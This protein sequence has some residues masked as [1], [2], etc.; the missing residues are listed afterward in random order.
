MLRRHK[1]E[2]HDTL[3]EQEA[4]HK[5]S[6]AARRVATPPRNKHHAKP[7]QGRRRRDL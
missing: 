3:H 1:R 6:A 4:P 2:S 7:N 5:D